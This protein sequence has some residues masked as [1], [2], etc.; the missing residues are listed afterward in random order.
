MNLRPKT[1]WAFAA[2]SASATIY[3]YLLYP[4]L[5]SLM[6]RKDIDVTAA[7]SA[8]GVEFSLLFC[9]F[10]EEKS[11]GEK[12]ANLRELRANYPRLDILAY[13]DCSTDGTAD[14]IEEAGLGIRLIRGEKRKGKAHGMKALV[15]LSQREFLVFTDANVLLASDALNRLCA[16]YSDD[17]VG[18]VCGLLR[19]AN[20]DGTPVSTAG[21]WY[22]RLEEV[23]K[24]LESRSGNVMGADGSIFSVR[25]NLYPEFEDSVLD[26]LTVSMSVIFQNRRLIKDPQVI[27]YERLV[28]LRSDDFRRRIRIAT[29]AFHTHLA[30]LPQLKRMSPSDRFRYWSHRYMRWHSGFFLLAATTSGI[31]ALHKSG[32]R[33]ATAALVATSAIAIPTGTFARLGPLSGLTH[34]LWSI[35]LTGLGVIR[36][37]QGHTV[38]TWKPPPR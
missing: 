36:A 3:P 8:D 21:N 32:R 34:I 14:M 26:D 24:T 23:T 5:L 13:D 29:R 37:R 11:L 15:S 7:D 16:D 35:L 19:Y 30:L 10:N 12:I 31:F 4:A 6:P 33:R 18:G 2:A 25:R 1:V 22:W 20:D 27:A 38:T 28:T 9:A 17:T